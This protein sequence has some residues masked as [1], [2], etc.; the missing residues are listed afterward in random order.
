[1][2]NCDVIHV[3]IFH[4]S[5]RGSAFSHPH[6]HPSVELQ[7]TFANKMNARFFHKTYPETLYSTYSTAICQQLQ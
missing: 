1:M 4:V 7:N 5:T 2:F 6:P 3:Q